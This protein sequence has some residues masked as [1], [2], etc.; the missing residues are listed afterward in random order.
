MTMIYIC[1]R[2]AKRPGQ[3][4]RLQDELDMLDA[5][6]DLKALQRLPHLNGVINETLR[7]HSAVPTGGLRKAPA[8]GITISGKYIPGNTVIC[9][10]RYSICRLESCF[11]NANAFVP[12]RWYSK[13]WMVKS[14]DAF[15]PFALGQNIALS[16]LRL[17]TA[18]LASRYDINFAAGD[19]G[20]SC[21]DDMLDHFTAAPGQLDLVFS[22]RK[23]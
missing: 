7:L 20:E 17:L 16:E 14:K 18:L 6:E 2:L 3:L 4:A 13:P 15:A 11:E 12:E 9:A 21:V 5:V 8:S 1:Y 10:P 23:G 19:N 22:K